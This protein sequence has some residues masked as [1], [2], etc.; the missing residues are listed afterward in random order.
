MQNNIKN[1]DLYKKK[2]SIRYLEENIMNLSN[3]T[4]LNTQIINEE[5]IAKYILN[6]NYYE[7]FEDNDKITEDYILKRQPHICREKLH[8][9]IKNTDGAY[10]YY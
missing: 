3:I 5:F 6:V 2:Y 8:L 4:I 7:G 9:E 1:S 10:Y